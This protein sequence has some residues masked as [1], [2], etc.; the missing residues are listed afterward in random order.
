MHAFRALGLFLKAW[1][2]HYELSFPL[3]SKSLLL[4]MGHSKTEN[5][6]FVESCERDTFKK[7]T[8][9]SYRLVG[10]NG[11]VSTECSPQA[12]CLSAQTLQYCFRSRHTQT[13]ETEKRKKV[14]AKEKVCICLCP[15]SSA[16][17]AVARYRI[18]LWHR[19]SNSNQLQWH[20]NP[21]K[22][23]TENFLIRVEN[24]HYTLQRPVFSS[25]GFLQVIYRLCLLNLLSIN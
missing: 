1:F 12:L 10:P 18:S 6:S 8:V 5:Q 24:K 3:H 20:V 25:S 23:E 7:E 17:T 21:V 22:L 9:W 2:M 14:W 4:N 13:S 16:Q 11:H 19:M 15:V